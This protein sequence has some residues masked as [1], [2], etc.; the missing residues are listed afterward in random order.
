VSNK[1]PPPRR[2]KPGYECC[3]AQEQPKAAISTERHAKSERMA[4]DEILGKAVRLRKLRDEAKSAEA[5]AKE[6]S[7]EMVPL[8]RKYG[9]KTSTTTTT[10]EF[11]TVRVQLIEAEKKVFDDDAV[12]QHLRELSKQ[13]GVDYIEKATKRVLCE[14]GLNALFQDGTINPL[15]LEKLSVSKPMSPVIKVVEVK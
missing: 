12:L 13:T 8:V 10:C 3:D 9:T 15:M 7:A 1:P 4:Q 14:E 5:Q 11:P 6:I 2:G